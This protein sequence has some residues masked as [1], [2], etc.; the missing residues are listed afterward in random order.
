MVEV[1]FS[2]RAIRDIEGIHAYI[3]KDSQRYAQG[4]VRRIL[5]AADLIAIF[6]RGGRM[7]PEIEL[8]AFREVI[9][10]NY[11]VIYHLENDERAEVLVVFHGR[12]RFPYGRISPGG[13]SPK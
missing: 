3:A 10:G 4:Q 13:R 8:D 7:V 5:N 1:I 6:P 2:A 12:R 9:V 11:R